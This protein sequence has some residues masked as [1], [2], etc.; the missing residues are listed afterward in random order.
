MEELTMTEE[1]ASKQKK[2]PSEGNV[3]PAHVVRRGAIAAS[4]WLRQSNAGYGYYD[5]SLS[6]SYKSLNTAKEGYS[7][8]FFGRN[9]EELKAVI[10]GASTWI[11]AQESAA[12]A[13][14]AA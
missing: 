7:T 4:I 10:E 12:A 2:A 13:K 9:Q 3:K 1:H 14:E 11:A 5:F 6:R 8:N